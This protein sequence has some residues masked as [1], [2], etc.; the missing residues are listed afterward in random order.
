MK[1]TLF[2]LLLGLASLVPTSAAANHVVAVLYFD[3][4]TGDGS[5]DVLQK[6]IADMMVTDLSSVPG[7]TVVEREKLEAIL[8]ELKLQRTRYFDAKTAVKIG[9]GL[10][11][12]YAVTGAIAAMD[13]QMRIDIR[14]VDIGS[15][16]VVLADRVVGTKDRFFELQTQLVNKFAHGMKIQLAYRP[17]LGAKVPN[18]GTL[19]EY[20][21]GIDLADQGKYVEAQEQLKSLVKKRPTFGLARSRVAALEQRLAAAGERRVE[22][23]KDAAAEL[24]RRAETYLEQHA[25][26]D[27][28]TKQEAATHL[29]YRVVQGAFLAR[30]LKATLSPGS[31][32]LIL[33]SNQSDGV[34]LMRAY[35]ASLETLI[36]EY[37]EAAAKYQFVSADL[38]G[39]DEKLA[40]SFDM[41]SRFGAAA[42]HSD[43][44][45][46]EFLLLGELEIFAEKD[47]RLRVAPPLGVL[48]PKLEKVGFELIERA[49][50]R[51]NDYDKGNAYE[52]LS[53]VY[54]LRSDTEKAVGAL[55]SL[56]DAFPTHPRYTF[57]EK[58]IQELLGMKHNHAVKQLGRYQD[59]LTRCDDMDFRIGVGAQIDHRIRLE[60]VSAIEAVLDEVIAKC[61][62]KPRLAS[63]W[64]YI[65]Q[66]AA[67]RAASHGLCPLYEEMSKRYWA[68]GG[69]EL[70]AA[71][72]HERLGGAC[73]FPLAEVPLPVCWMLD[74]TAMK[75][76]QGFQDV[77]TSLLAAGPLSAPKGRWYAEDRMFRLVHPQDD[78]K[79]WDECSAVLAFEVSGTREA[80]TF[81]VSVKKGKTVKAVTIRP[82]TKIS[83]LTPEAV[84]DAWSVAW[85]QPR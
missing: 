33:P 78:K 47:N 80:P 7:V 14:L 69:S 52:L 50:T 16:E 10:G 8:G 15:S 73:P 18:V 31:P 27:A 30:T 57:F 32:A 56:L 58:R 51:G 79:R 36:R 35:A 13:P 19:L 72:F 12:R 39:E 9:Q 60:G 26:K 85:A 34:R 1:P 77:R 68:V 70:S 25:L 74:F 2:A 28:T 21:K 11:A 76:T 71:K 20:S 40:R 54:Y 22:I 48:D 66:G 44:R 42:Q 82:K 37:D 38:P 75:T 59:A 46:A 83:D 5:L 67:H 53:S 64:Q 63:A 55:Q 23:R 17:N 84:V 29:A 24:Q 4:N 45:L 65:F 62:T 49:K 43:L 6:G 3:N 81:V 61:R 41:K